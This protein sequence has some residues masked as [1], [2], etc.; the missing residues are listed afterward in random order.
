MMKT[1]IYASVLALLMFIPAGCEADK[2]KGGTEIKLINE[3]NP[4]GAASTYLIAGNSRIIGEINVSVAGKNINVTYKITMEGWRLSETNLAV[5]NDPERI[6]QT[7][8]GNPRPRDFKYSTKHHPSVTEYTYVVPKAGLST[9][10]IAAHA[11]V[12]MPVSESCMSMEEREALIPES[13]VKVSNTLTSGGPGLYRINLS[14][15]GEISG[16]YTGWCADNNQRPADFKT[17]H[18]VSSYSKS[19]D[20]GK[21]VPIPANL[22]FLN[23]M[24]NKYHGKYALPVIQAA[25]WRLMNGTFNNPD[26]G[27]ELN[28]DQIK[29]YN[30]VVSDVL[31]NGRNYL[32]GQSDY[33]VILLDSGDNKKYQNVLFMFKKCINDYQ[34]EISWGD[35]YRFPGNIV[36]KYFAYAVQ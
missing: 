30:N 26:G 28:S 13:A 25:V 34:I 18:L 2:D 14:D 7:E 16:E 6:P 19:A 29:Q 35:G 31:A 24:L 27:I 3:G 32:P 12:L 1:G 23:Y 11:Y 33:L 8:N 4:G 17:G 20:L 36:A 10:Y 15:A 22:P 9:A 5:E 21:I